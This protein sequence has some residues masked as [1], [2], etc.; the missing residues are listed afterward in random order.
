VVFALS[1]QTPESEVDQEA[2]RS[3]LKQ[4]IAGQW[5]LF[6]DAWVE[7]DGARCAGFFCEDGMH[8]RPQATIDTGRTEIGKTFTEILS[9]YKVEYC[10]QTTL[11]IDLCSDLII[12]YGTYEQ[13]W[14][15]SE[16]AT[17]GGY[18]AVWKRCGQDSIG[19][20]RLIFN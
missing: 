19:I 18:F 9:S 17:Q 4:E 6:F 1:C 10:N 14:A 7:G 8:F 3:K 5:R 13:K 20:Y 12:E 2:M 16:E 15:V 11:G